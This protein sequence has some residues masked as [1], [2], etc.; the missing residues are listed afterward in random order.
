MALVLSSCFMAT[1][2]VA[3]F[4]FLA[5]KEHEKS[6]LL[7]QAL[8]LVLWLVQSEMHQGFLCLGGNFHFLPFFMEGV[9]VAD[10]NE[11]I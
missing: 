2:I 5:I 8:L 9:R 4:K 7:A 3:K 6:S 11:S 10:R 1:L